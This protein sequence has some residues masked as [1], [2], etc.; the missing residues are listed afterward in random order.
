MI[1]ETG[2]V[3][4]T[5]EAAVSVVMGIHEV[6]K[7]LAGAPQV[8]KALTAPLKLVQVPVKVGGL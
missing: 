4:V 2:A 6:Q 1:V 3:I 5:R 7:E 8:C